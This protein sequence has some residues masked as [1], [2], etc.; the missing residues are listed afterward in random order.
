LFKAAEAWTCNPAWIFYDIAVNTRYGSGSY[1]DASTLD[2]WALYYISKLC[3]ETLIPD[4]L[5]GYEPRFSCNMFIQ[6]QE[7]AL[8]VLMT[9][10]SIFRGMCYFAG[11]VVTP[12][13]DVASS[14]VMLFNS[15]NVH[16]G[17][18][19][20][21]GTAKKARHTAALISWTNPAMGYQQAV[22]YV[23][24]EAGIARYG[25]QPTQVTAFG[26]TSQG[27]A[28]RLGLW[29]LA[30]EL[31]ET[32]VVTFRAGM[33]GA[34]CR[35]GDVVQI[36]DPYRAGKT[37]MGGRV[38]PG[39]TTLTVL[40]DDTV[41]LVAGT[42]TLK[43]TM[44]NGTVEART[45]TTGIGATNSLTVSAPFSAIPETM[46]LLQLSTNMALYRVLGVR[47]SSAVDYEVTALL[48]DPTKYSYETGL[49]ISASGGVTQRTAA[50]PT[51]VTTNSY[52]KILN[53]RVAI[54]LDVSWPNNTA[55]VG[56]E[57]AYSRDNRPF[58]KMQVAGSSA[59]ADE[60]LPG[61]YRVR[62]QAFFAGITNTFVTEV[63]LT[64]ADPN[65]VPS[66]LTIPAT[67][68]GSITMA[69]TTNKPA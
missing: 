11:G 56:Y 31:L 66:S 48:H 23:Q 47:E 64:I 61:N 60:V 51:P 50:A 62:V 5:G 3:D 8:K 26:C 2:K 21:T 33:E 44:P 41:T 45:V 30:T 27:Q 9:M 36:A 4:G 14:P 18:F 43:C 34:A 15:A 24:D 39:T 16:D 63:T 57:C 65:S 7:D 42:Y 35:P 13:A 20:Y 68:P 10:A 12:V 38:L 17:A 29:T 58:V 54:Q 19:A 46:W 32:E 53:S 1:L 37:R 69:I 28:R 49:R 40:L 52:V 59:S 25:Y 6:A 67:T 55:A 22:E